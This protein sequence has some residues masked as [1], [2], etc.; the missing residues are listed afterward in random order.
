M[1]P[2]GIEPPSQRLKGARSATELEKHDLPTY[3]SGLLGSTQGHLSVGRNLCPVLPDPGNW[4]TATECS[5]GLVVGCGLSSSTHELGSAW[6]Q[7]RQRDARAG[8]EPAFS[9]VMSP[10]GFLF[11]T[12]RCAPT[13][14]DVGAKK[15][16]AVPCGI[17]ELLCGNSGSCSAFHSH[18]YQYTSPQCHIRTESNSFLNA[19]LTSWNLNIGAGLPL[20]SFVATGSIFFLRAHSDMVF[21]RKL[22]PFAFAMSDIYFAVPT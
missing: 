17:R 19:A 6:H 11:P 8:F 7:C 10:A 22:N 4:P 14:P 18:T 12:Q 5:C 3:P 15:R 16:R 1:P 2:D 20:T 9:R 13:S 21:R